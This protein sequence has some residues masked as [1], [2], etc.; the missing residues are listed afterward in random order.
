MGREAAELLVR[1]MRSE[2]VAP[3]AY[4]RRHEV[5]LRLAASTAPPRAHS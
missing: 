3:D 2:L 4:T 1:V 5:N